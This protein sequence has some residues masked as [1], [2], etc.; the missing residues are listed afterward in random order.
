MTTEA[1]TRKE[2]RLQRRII[3]VAAVLFV[4]FLTLCMGI[5]FPIQIGFQLVTGWTNF[6]ARTLPVLMISTERTAWFLFALTLFTLGVHF[7]CKRLFHRKQASEPESVD[8]SEKSNWHL[9]WTLSLAVMCLLLTMSGICVISMTH[10]TWWIMTGK[11]ETFLE[12][13]DP[14]FPVLSFCRDS[15]RAR[16]SLDNLRNLGF[17]MHNDHKESR[18]LPIA[19]TFNET[20][21]PLHGWGAQ[22]LPHLD[23]VELYHSIDFHQPWTAEVNRAPFQTKI[24]VFQNPGMNSDY[25]NG[26]SSQEA[27]QSYCPTHYAMSSRLLAASG[28]LDFNQITDGISNTILGGEVNSNIRPWGAPLN[29]RDPARGLNGSPHGFG[30]PSPKNTGMVFVDGSARFIS[31]DIDPQVLKALSTPN[32]GEAVGEF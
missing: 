4:G 21:K 19:S 8:V 20:G 29:V 32:G 9:R 30:G 12:K 5:V 15:F 1:I 11:P 16:A 31:K 3:A 7:V 2:K 25:D 14:P 27:Y 23:Q 26:K 18:Q 17:V 10:Q 22:L 24:Y 28:E 13:H 6:I